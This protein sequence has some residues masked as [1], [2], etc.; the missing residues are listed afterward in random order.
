[1]NTFDEQT[2]R[3]F[4]KTA[5]KCRKARC[6]ASGVGAHE[7]GT[8]HTLT[9]VNARLSSQT[10][11]AV[12]THH[13][14]TVS[15]DAPDPESNGVKRRRVSFVGG[16]DLTTGRYDTPQHHLYATLHTV[17]Q[18]DFRNKLGA[19]DPSLGPREPWHDVHAL[20]EGSVAR[21][22]VANF[23][24]RWKKQGS[25][26]R[27]MRCPLYAMNRDP[28]F[29]LADDELPGD[30]LGWDVQMFRSISHRSAVNV[31]DV[32]SD[33]AVAYIHQIRRAQRFLYIENQYFYG[34]S[35]FWHHGDADLEC[36]HRIPYEV[37]MR[38]VSKIRQRERLVV[39]VCL[40]LYPEGD[41]ASVTMQG[42]LYF[43][44]ETFRMM[45][46]L[47]GDAL[48]RWGP[49]GAHP[50]DYL[51]VFC[52]VK[53]EA[54]PFGAIPPLPP[55]YAKQQ[56]A[57]RTGRQMVYV[58]SK[59]MVADDEYVLI[60][61]ANINERSMSG[62]RDTEVAVGAV[63]V[64]HS[65]QT[66]AAALPQGQVSGF[67]MTLWA[68]HLGQYHE[69]FHRPHS[70]ECVRRVRRLAEENWAAF[71]DDSAIAPLPHGQWIPYPYSIDVTGELTARIPKLPDS[72]ANLLGSRP[73]QILTLLST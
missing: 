40:P 30:R 12:F 56:T 46:R 34:S 11:G 62:A 39:Y 9:W 59:A 29:H 6:Y 68:E 69:S 70:L 67:R 21:D 51:C 63:E 16:V 52:P 58:H 37:A 65:K 26:K 27:G 36:K 2:V 3:F 73:P 41:P 19:F 8:T 28:A 50:L 17:H 72:D 71:M 4:A 33:I 42:I 14:K 45:F 64:K 24:S 55:R 47:V 20:V 61:S 57:L 23:E 53:R 31:E 25:R 18:N 35:Q 49:E 5:V 38:V 15:L 44:A 22:I 48:R 10:S 13:Q 54:Y 32:E 1:M 43:Q 66:G 7:P 60:G